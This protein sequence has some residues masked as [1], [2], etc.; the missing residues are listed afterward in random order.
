MGR[1]IT[2]HETFDPDITT[3]RRIAKRLSDGSV[4]PIKMYNKRWLGSKKIKYV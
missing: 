1:N 2:E 3:L 4:T